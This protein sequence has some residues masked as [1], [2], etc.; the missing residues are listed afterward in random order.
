MSD[1]FRGR[2]S[3][4]SAG[5]PTSDHESDAPRGFDYTDAATATAAAALALRT[6]TASTSAATTP[7][8]QPPNNSNTGGVGGF[9]YSPSTA[10]DIGS[11]EFS[12]R[13]LVADK[14]PEST[15]SD[16]PQSFFANTASSPSRGSREWNANSGSGSGGGFQSSNFSVLSVAASS[17]FGHHADGGGGLLTPCGGGYGSSSPYANGSCPQPQQQQQPGLH[18][19][20]PS[21]VGSQLSI[22]QPSLMSTQGGMAPAA[23]TTGGGGSVPATATTGGGGGSAAKRPARRNPWGSETYSD[24]I[25][26]AIESYPEK[27]ATL[28][29]IYD[30]IS[31]NYTYFRERSDPPASAGWKV[32][33]GSCG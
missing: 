7:A 13:R 16:Y 12:S 22:P 15:T 32:S 3:T 26:K 14:T 23:T 11:Q 30:Y 19:G 24:L 17:P 21:S 1:L 18:S 25:A 2:A 31:T 6:V 4:W 29:Q 8:D 27:Q 33:T 28:Q 20:S 10:A 9:H 5:A